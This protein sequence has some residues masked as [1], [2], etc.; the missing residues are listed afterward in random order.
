MDDRRYY[1]D[2]YYSGTHAVEAITEALDDWRE[3][4]HPHLGGGGSRWVGEKPGRSGSRRTED[5]KSNSEVAV[6]NDYEQRKADVV[7][8]LSAFAGLQALMDRFQGTEP[9]IGTVLR[10]VK[11]F[12]G[13]TGELVMERATKDAFGDTLRFNV[14]RPSEYVFV[15]FRAPNGQWYTT[16]Q[17]GKDVSEWSAVLKNIGDSE[18]QLVSDWV[19]VPVPETPDMAAV[20]PVEFARQMFG[21]KAEKAT[22]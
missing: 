22:D 12:D 19:D 15:A 17:R 16:S 5:M 1:E 8:A 14:E 6:V 3:R 13:G 18:C 20:D 9:P 2:E 10:W 21:K 11:K 4:P 7:K